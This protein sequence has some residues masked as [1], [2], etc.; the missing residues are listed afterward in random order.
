[1]PPGVRIQR[2]SHQVMAGRTTPERLLLNF[3]REAEGTRWLRRVAQPPVR[4]EEEI[5]ATRVAHKLSLHEHAP[6]LGTA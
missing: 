1:M 6:P 3:P 2:L 4:R 5:G